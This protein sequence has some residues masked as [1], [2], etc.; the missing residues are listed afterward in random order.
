MDKLKFIMLVGLAG[1]GKTT[2]A[3][4]LMAGRDDT[5]WHSSDVIREEV[6]GDVNEQGK[7]GDVFAIMEQRTKESLRNG[8]NVIYDATNIN[9]KKRK[10]LLSQ[11][12]RELEIDKIVLYIATPIDEVLRRNAGRDRIVPQ[13]VIEDKMYKNMQ[14]PIYSE[15]WDKI[16]FEYDDDTLEYDLPKQFTDAIRAGVIFGREGYRLMGEL[17]SHFEEFF[18]IY[19]LSQDSKYHSFSVSRHIYYVYRYVLENYPDGRDKEMMLWT[20]LL[21]DVGKAYCKSFRNRKGEETR[22]ANFIGHEY[23]GSQMAIPFLK[24]MNFEDEFIHN[25]ATLIQFHM[26]LLDDNANK[27][28]LLDRVG[29]DTYKKLEFLRDADTKAH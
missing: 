21:H 7:N 25:V 20:A 29:K 6:L 19:D 26:Y 4:E 9:R 22:Y 10:H 27:Q 1:S 5:D 17:A 12:P 23:V 24:K 15:G 14:V 8:R 16:V 3:K 2:V 18:P 13:E 11:L 28:K